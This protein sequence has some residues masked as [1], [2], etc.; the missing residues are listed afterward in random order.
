MNEPTADGAGPC[1]RGLL[2]K[3]K[4]MVVKPHAPLGTDPELADLLTLGG[5]GL[6]Y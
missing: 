1:A 6:F 4:Q 2:L 3:I 5:F